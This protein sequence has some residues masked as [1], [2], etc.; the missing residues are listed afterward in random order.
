MRRGGFAANIE[1]SELM[2]MSELYDRGGVR[3]ALLWLR[4]SHRVH[5]DAQ[6]MA[7]RNDQARGRSPRLEDGQM[8]VGR[9]AERILNDGYPRGR[10]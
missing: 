10:E 3:R 5:R 7:R 6:Q 4:L 8:G 9:A 1:R 2:Q